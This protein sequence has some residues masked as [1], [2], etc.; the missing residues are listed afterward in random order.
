MI[1]FVGVLR[2][3][4]VKNSSDKN[5]AVWEAFYNKWVKGRKLND[6]L[7]VRSYDCYRAYE[8]GC[9]LEVLLSDEPEAREYYLDQYVRKAMNLEI[10]WDNLNMEWIMSHYDD[11]N[12]IMHIG[13]S[14]RILQEDNPEYF[15]AM[16]K[17]LFDL[18]EAK[19][20]MISCFTNALTME[21][22]KQDIMLS[23]NR[24]LKEEEGSGD[25]QFCERK[26]QDIAFQKQEYEETREKML[27]LCNN[28]AA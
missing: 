19:I 8:D 22:S 11:V 7:D 17:K 1:V 9:S 4:K 21:L 12:Y 24:Y 3:I 13:T 15:E 10:S 28:N 5:A 16:P 14:F 2:N 18:L 20:Y 26:D 25:A 6:S 27:G 23:D